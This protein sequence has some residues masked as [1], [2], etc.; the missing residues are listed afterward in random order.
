MQRRWCQTE[1]RKSVQNYE[2][3]KRRRALYN[4]KLGSSFSATN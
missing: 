2:E 4:S 3:M 1:Q